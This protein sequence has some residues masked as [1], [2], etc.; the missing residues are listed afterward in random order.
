MWQQLTLVNPRR[1]NLALVQSC[2]SI[3]V[4][5]RARILLVLE[6]TEFQT[7]GVSFSH[8]RIGKDFAAS[9]APFVSR[10]FSSAR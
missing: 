7:V 5:M 1:G 9:T 2:N 4:L 10:F 3:R 8:R 6:T